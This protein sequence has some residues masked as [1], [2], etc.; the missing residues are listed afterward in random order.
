LNEGLPPPRNR[1]MFHWKKKAS[2]RRPDGPPVAPNEAE[3]I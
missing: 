3:A 2:K 1:R